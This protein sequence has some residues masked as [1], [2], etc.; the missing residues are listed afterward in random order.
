MPAGGYTLLASG[1]RR[2]LVRDDLVDVLGP[3]LLAR[4]LV[5]PADA[6]PITGGRGGTYRVRLAGAPPAVLRLGRRGGVVARLLRE[7]YLGV[8]PRPWR[9]VAVTIAA[10]AGGAPVPEVLAARVD[11]WLLY[12]SA[13]LTEEVAD[14]ATAIDALRA[15]PPAERHRIAAAVARAVSALHAAGVAHP[16]LNLTNILIGAERASIVDLDRARAGAG[17]LARRAR[18][19]GLARLCRSARKL[20]P[21][22]RTIDRDTVRAFRDAYGGEAANACAS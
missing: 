20:D 21:D 9:E 16:D 22:G 11:G 17:G 10:R 2:A 5:V 13:V 4:S 14:A 6:W 8:C 12:R 19:R 18:R 7:T 1:A 15:A 3:W